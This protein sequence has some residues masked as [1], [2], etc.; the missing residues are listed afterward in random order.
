[1]HRL[2]SHESR[3]VYSHWSRLWEQRSTTT[4]SAQY[5]CH[6]SSTAAVCYLC[7]CNA[8]VASSHKLATLAHTRA[9]VRARTHTSTPHAPHAHTHNTTAGTFT[10]TCHENTHGHSNDSPIPSTAR[11]QVWPTSALS[12]IRCSSFYRTRRPVCLRRWPGVSL[13]GCYRPSPRYR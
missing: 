4:S 8:T 12:T 1:M 3:H 9:H 13:G 10:A 11:A 2:F 6:L 5:G 7:L